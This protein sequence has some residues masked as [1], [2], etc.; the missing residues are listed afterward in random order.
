MRYTRPLTSF[1]VIS[2]LKLPFLYADVPYLGPADG[3]VLQSRIPP[4]TNKNITHTAPLNMPRSASP[5]DSIRIG[6]ATP[7][8]IEIVERCPE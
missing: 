7:M 1:F 8:S 6:N 5:Y 3:G 2:L 4:I